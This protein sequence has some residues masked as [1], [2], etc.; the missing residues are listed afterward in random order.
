MIHNRECTLS[1]SPTLPHSDFVRRLCLWLCL[2]NS[3]SK[4]QD[5]AEQSQSQSQTLPN[6]LQ[7]TTTHWNTLQRTEIYCNTLQD[8]ARRYQT[9]PNAK[10]LLVFVFLIAL[11]CLACNRLQHRHC[12]RLQHRRNT[13]IATDCNT[14]NMCL[15][16]Y[17]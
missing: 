14:P 7:H 9:Q 17:S 10:Y 8:T 3:S 1:V 4:L 2:S 11:Q 5:T 12:N 16:L 15:F 6:R 13:D